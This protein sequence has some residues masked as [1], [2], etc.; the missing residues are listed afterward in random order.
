MFFGDDRWLLFS[1]A[2]PGTF[3]RVGVQPSK[4]ILKQKTKQNKNKQKT[5]TH[6]RGEGGRF[7]IYSAFIR[8]KSNLAFE[9]AFTHLTPGLTSDL[10]GSVN[11]HRGALL[12]VPQ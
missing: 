10:Q 1:G 7:S 6:K 5:K 4:K 2:D 3:V 12:L 8:S 11:V 9:T